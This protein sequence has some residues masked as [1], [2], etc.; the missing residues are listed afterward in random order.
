MSFNLIDRFLSKCFV[1]RNRLQL[2]GCVCLW[3]ASKY[4]E[5]FSPEM[6]DF[7]YISDK[8]FQKPEMLRMEEAV[9][10]FLDQARN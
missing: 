2:L 7:V 8:A 6:N 4:H 10:K 5:I 3:I 1:K 9:V